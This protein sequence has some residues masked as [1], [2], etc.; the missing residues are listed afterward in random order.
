MHYFT[1]HP[2]RVI[3]DAGRAI[4]RSSN[5]NTTSSVDG[6]VGPIDVTGTVIQGPRGTT[7]QDG[8]IRVDKK[9]GP[10]NVNASLTTGGGWNGQVSMNYTWGRPQNLAEEP[11]MS[12]TTSPLSLILMV[13]VFTFAWIGFSKC[14]NRVDKDK[15]DQY[16]AHGGHNDTLLAE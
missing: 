10:Y 7:V 9:F 11:Y 5:L 16:V 4:A 14:M 3:R 12:E 13:T 8:S 15:D 1:A 2:D 6:N